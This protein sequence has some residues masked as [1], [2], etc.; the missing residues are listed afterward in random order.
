[1]PVESAVIPLVGSTLFR[2]NSTY[3]GNLDQYC[4]NYLVEP[5]KNA[6]TGKETFIARPRGNVTTS[7]GHDFQS[8]GPITV[9]TFIA[10][11]RSWESSASS[12]GRLAVVGLDGGNIRLSVEALGS[13]TVAPTAGYTGVHA[14]IETLV[15]STPTLL[16]GSRE[17]TTRQSQWFYHTEGSGALT[18]ISGGGW[19]TANTGNIVGQSGYHFVM[20]TN[21]LIYN[22]ELNSISS[23][24]GDYIGNDSIPDGGVGLAKYKDYVVGFGKKTTTL[25]HVS[26]SVTGSP[27]IRDK[28]SSFNIGAFKE[29]NSGTSGDCII[30]GFDNVFWLGSTS[31][32][33]PFGIWTF[34]NLTPVMISDASLNRLLFAS[35]FTTYA[36]S[37]ISASLLGC[38]YLRGRRYVVGRISISGVYYFLIDLETKYVSYFK[39]EDLGYSLETEWTTTRYGIIIPTNSNTTDKLLY[40]Q[41]DPEGG[42]GRDSDSGGGV[43]SITGVIQI[44]PV[45]LGTDKRKILHKLRVI[46]ENSVGA[47]DQNITISWSDDDGNTWSSNRTINLENYNNQWISGLGSFR[48][49][50]FKLTE[51]SNGSSQRSSMTALELEYTVCN[52]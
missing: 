37:Y 9:P 52:N 26:D 20:G 28:G 8:G 24:P 44:G 50:F 38:I 4:L 43:D 25:Y 31:N 7:G 48:R 3:F 42:G 2:G 32:G 40:F 17:S 14:L 29:I 49:R 46:G 21:G 47:T 19:P 51:I 45:D 18:A 36:A 15:G 10:R 12:T 5:T 23:W 1:M 35:A 13:Y 11:C 22:S 39:F 27:L 41:T 30:H 6:L 34:D 33:N 16:V